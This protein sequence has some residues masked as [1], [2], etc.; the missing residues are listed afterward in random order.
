[1]CSVYLR[2]ISGESLKFRRRTVAEHRENV[3][4]CKLKN[5]MTPLLG[6][7][8]EVKSQERMKNVKNT[9]Q[10]KFCTLLLWTVST[11][12]THHT[13]VTK[14]M[15][16]TLTEKWSQSV[17]TVFMCGTSYQYKKACA[18]R[19]SDFAEHQASLLIHHTTSK[20]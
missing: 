19:K 18:W 13:T 9:Q 16:D 7:L 10:T 17:N 3:Q 15:T 12:I 14:T 1:M 11:L 4:K 2:G 6:F 5:S 20:G 8:W